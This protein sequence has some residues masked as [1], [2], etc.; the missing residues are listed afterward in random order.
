MWVKPEKKAEKEVK[1]LVMGKYES[2]K[3]A[4]EHEKEKNLGSS[5]GRDRDWGGGRG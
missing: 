4:M 2:R 5:N 3:K 1:Y